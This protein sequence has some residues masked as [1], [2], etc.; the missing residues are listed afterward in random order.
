MTVNKNLCDEFDVM[1]QIDES[2]RLMSK[3]ITPAKGLDHKGGAAA[4]SP[5][6]SSVG[7]SLSSGSSVDSSDDVLG[8]CPSLDIVPASQHKVEK[9]QHKVDENEGRHA[10]E[11]LL[12]ENPNRFVLFPIQDNDVSV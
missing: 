7:P 12:K 9:T 2:N 5:S 8:P 1:V 11:P 10:V 4:V 6:S 3:S